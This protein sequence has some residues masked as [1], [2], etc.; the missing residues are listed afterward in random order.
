MEGYFKLASNIN[1]NEAKNVSSLTK[2]TEEKKSRTTLKDIGELVSM[3]K[4]Y[5]FRIIFN[6]I[7]IS[8][9]VLFMSS[10]IFKEEIILSTM[11]S[12]VSLILGIV[13]TIIS[14]ISIFISFY[15]L[16]RTN[17]INESN[18]STLKDLEDVVKKTTQTNAE[19]FEAIK[20]LKQEFSDKISN[21]PKQTAVETRKHFDLTNTEIT[22][23]TSVIDI[24]DDDLPF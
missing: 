17:E 20:S 23:S 12:W 1:L 4:K 14:I 7:I 10:F 3:F 18:I 2:P 22:S 9:F 13:A 21:L 11:N 19:T 8:I 6:I 15:N 16:E 5:W 24:D